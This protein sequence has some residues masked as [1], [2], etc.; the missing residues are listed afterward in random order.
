[1]PVPD[2]VG[3]PGV[4]DGSGVPGV[5]AGGVGESAVPPAPVELPEEFPDPSCAYRLPARTPKTATAIPA[6]TFMIW[7]LEGPG[8]PRRCRTCSVA[9]LK[10]CKHHHRGKDPRH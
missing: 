4:V 5:A 1:S 7:Y 6:V 8:L 2:V 10:S 3:V 9:R